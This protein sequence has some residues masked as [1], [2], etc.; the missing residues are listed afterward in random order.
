[1]SVGC[2]SPGRTVGLG[3][4]AQM[5]LGTA[6]LSRVSATGLT[7]G[8]PNCGDLDVQGW[9]SSAISGMVTLRAVAQ[10]GASITF[11]A[12]ASQFTA[13]TAQVRPLS[14]HTR[15]CTVQH[16]S[17]HSQGVGREPRPRLS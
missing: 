9:S 10:A 14:V 16:A 4:S 3:S 15:A 2:I 12:T 13:L 5:Q 11:Q 7:V 6:E 1:M 8:A 17:Q